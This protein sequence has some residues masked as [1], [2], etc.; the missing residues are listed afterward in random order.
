RSDP[1]QDSMNNEMPPENYYEFNRLLVLSDPPRTKALADKELILDC[2]HETMFCNVCSKISTDEIANI[3]VN[4]S[5]VDLSASTKKNA[6]TKQRPTT[7]VNRKESPS[8][9][10]RTSKTKK[11][12]ER[13]VV[14]SVVLP[15]PRKYER[16]TRK[17]RKDPDQ[18][19]KTA[20]N[21]VAVRKNRAEA[22]V[23]E[24][25]ILE[26]LLYLEKAFKY[27]SSLPVPTSLPDPR[28][29]GLDAEFGKSEFVAK[30]NEL[31]KIGL[32]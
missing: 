29:L 7:S 2:P 25:L 3:S 12:E 11:K 22:K 19:K 30:D 23:R 21:Y 32:N 8:S 14:N 28:E 13:I 4:L 1:P 15:P 5:S 24:V 20:K 18:K 9:S 10:N 16:K 26:R 27:L 6:K 31:K 17:Q